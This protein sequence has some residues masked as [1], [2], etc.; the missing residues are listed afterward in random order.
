[1]K[2]QVLFIHCAGPQGN[3]Q[4]SEGLVEYLQQNLSNEYSLLNPSMPNPEEPVY[5][6]WKKEL[7]KN[8]D[9]LTGEVI[10]VGH[11]LGGTVLLKYLSEEECN[12]SIRGLFIVATPYWGIDRDWSRSDFVLDERFYAKLPQSIDTYFYHSMHDETVPINHLVQLTK[13]FA[14]TT[15][16]IQDGSSHLFENGLAELVVD[17][18][19]SNLER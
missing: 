19:N 7:Q 14:D 13:G 16:R 2:K 10:L 18:K 9:S 11:S 4:G 17:I 5:H 6:Q 8:F 1:M 12:V 3:Q 15:I